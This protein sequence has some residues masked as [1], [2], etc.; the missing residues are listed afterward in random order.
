MHNCRAQSGRRHANEAAGKSFSRTW[1]TGFEGSLSVAFLA[2]SSFVSPVA[3]ASASGVTAPITLHIRNAVNGQDCT[4]IGAWNSAT[5]TCTLMYDVQMAPGVGDG[6][7][8]DSDGITLDGNGHA[9]TGNN[10]AGSNGIYLSGGTGVNIKNFRNVTNFHDGIYLAGSSN[11]TISGD[12]SYSN[13][14]NGINLT[15]ASN[16]NT[17]SGSSF[18]IHDI[19]I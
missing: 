4:I 18:G 11:N 8:I 19:G 9:I 3:T 15:S 2:G 5:L 7:H 16:N 17:I 10:I 13:G 14:N 1:K 12:T 6:N